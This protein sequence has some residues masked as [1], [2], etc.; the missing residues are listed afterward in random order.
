MKRSLFV[1]SSAYVGLSIMAAIIILSIEGCA[2]KQ[3]ES[4]VA[5]I[6]TAPITLTDF[7]KMY[8]RSNGSNALSNPVSQEERERF[9]DLMIKYR[10]KLT[11]AYRQGMEKRPEVLSE[12]DQYRGSL[13]TSYLSERE[14]VRPNVQMIFNRT[15]EEI[16]ASHI[17]LVFTPNAKAEDS[18]LVYKQAQEIIAEA[19]AGK[20]F[21]QLALAFSKDPSV[22][23]NKGDLY[24]LTVGRLVPE[25]EDAAY[26][27]KA[28]EVSPAPV[29]TRFGLHIIKVTDRRPTQGERQASHIM[30][31]FQAQNPAPEDTLAAYQR[32][33]TIKDS[34]AQGI[35][36]ADLAM[37]NSDDVGSN[38]RGGD[39]G[40]FARGRWPQPFDE[41][42]F[43]L[44][45][46]KPSSIVRTA[47]GYHLILCTNT[48]PPKTFDEL[49]Q[50][51]QNQY[52]QQRFQNDFAAYTARIKKEVQFTRNDSIVA[53]F[54]S[55]LDSTKMVRD[56]GWAEA[57]P[58]DLARAPMF[59]VLG[60]TISVDSV[61]TM[62]KGHTE[63][64]TT[65][66]HKLSLGPIVD[67]LS[68]QVLF[69]AKSELLEK[70]DP[71]FAGL[72]REYKEGILLYQIE[73]DQVWNKIASSDSLLRLYF[74]DHRD[75]FA[76]PARVA[77]SEIRG[78]NEAQAQ[79][80]REKLTAGMTMEQV[81]VEDSLRMTA[82]TNYQIPFAP[83]KTSLSAK[84]AA[85]VAAVGA[86]LQKESA[87]RVMI[88]AYADTSARKA[89]N[90]ALAKKR[91]EYMKGMLTKTQ[92]I[93]AGRILAET[94]P[95]RFAAAKAKDSTGILNRI[96]LQIVGLQPMVTGK[97]EKGLVA[98]ASDERAKRADSLAVG[99]LSM[100]FR[101]KTGWA[102]VR[103][104]GVE[105]ARLKTFE[106]AG[107][108]VSSAF[109]DYESK[110]LET[111]W[112]NRV[113]QY[114]PVTEHKE[115]LKNAFAK[116]P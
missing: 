7:E 94:R 102:V 107:P 50:E 68:D 18:A 106:E 23:Q 72:L 26:A 56:S 10:L 57:L 89:Q 99:G 49:K 39:L 14:I 55:G 60:R 98:P 34:L 93:S 81:A 73:Q 30:I 77:F 32:I 13:A 84:A 35:P 113:K 64:S 15:R 111:E 67:K 22:Q 20:D 3:Q 78:I 36:F 88:L 47:Y 101:F 41:T 82:R 112:L 86:L 42:A 17:L 108:E 75:K 54:V 58:R 2:P 12:I 59:K 4:I 109:Q 38:S 91:L 48:R 31:R 45:V 66:L 61:I 29:K 53:L 71:E 114:A 103:N 6:G 33:A 52:Q 46:G 115:L 90:E 105:P 70:D 74:N 62:I 37:R 87:T 79:T 25:F 76:F 80:I 96:D 104:D 97:I 100:P 24:Y 16:R 65:T 28:G 83:G 8:I 1:R 116:T 110:R 40:W 43:L 51:I 95:Q 11:D 5:N 9:L 21:G 92:N 63:W 27:L 85:P 69:A 19:K 44:P